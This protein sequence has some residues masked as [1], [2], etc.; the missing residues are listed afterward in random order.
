MLKSLLSETQNP[1]SLPDITNK[2]AA[3]LRVGLGLVFVAGGWWKLSRAIDSTQSGDFVARYMAD[4]GY[5]NGF[6]AD[7]LF[8]SRDAVLTPLSFLTMLSAFELLCGILLLAGLLVRPLSILYAFLLWT[9]VIALPVDVIGSAGPDEAGYFSP[10]ILVQIRD[11]AMSGMFLT[12]I[13]L[14]SGAYSLD[15]KLFGRGAHSER[16]TWD[17][18]GLVLRVSLAL[19]FL[20]AGFFAGYD[21]IK[22]W[23]DV[24]FLLAVV[25]I[26]LVA[27]HGTRIFAI[28]AGLIVVYYCFG[29]IDF[30]NAPWDNF[31]AIKRELAFIAS[32]AVLAIWGGGAHL[33]AINAIREP[34]AVLFGQK[35]NA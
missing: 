12:L 3:I 6:F 25:G 4:N 22:V 8:A 9:F 14:G 15:R 27:G 28:I 34:V 1:A 35:A 20:V 21:H 26:G 16:A 11:I 17:D 29:K 10:A 18:I 2:A 23:F 31:N 33:K 7:Y 24:P 30:G 32:S 5:I 19:T 13:A